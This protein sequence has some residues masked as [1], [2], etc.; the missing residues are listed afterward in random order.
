MSPNVRKTSGKLEE[1]SEQKLLISLIRSGANPELAKKVIS[2]IRSKIRGD[3]SSRKIHQMA[4]RALNKESKKLA[5]LYH[6]DR[7]ISELGPDGFVFEQFMAE[8]LRARG[9][10][11]STNQILQGACVSHEVDLIAEKEGFRIFVECKFHN[12]RDWTNDVKVALYVH[13][14]SLDLKNNPENNF[15]EFWL[16]SNTKFSKDAI[17][18]GDCVGLKIV[19]QNHPTDYAISHM[20][21]KTGI[22]PITSLSSIRKSIK[23][24]LVEQGAFL[25]QHLKDD[26]SLLDQFRLS[27]EQIQR[28]HKEIDRIINHNGKSHGH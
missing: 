28:V 13:A 20:V 3:I 27:P 24:R 1:F 15:D 17:Q 14:R 5:A 2:K 22:H 7:A 10:K 18:Y 26:F 21:E 12:H 9:F 25:I 19:G 4:C 16:V 11:V 6:L 23:K 8:L